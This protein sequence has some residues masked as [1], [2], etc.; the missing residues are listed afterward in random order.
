MQ[1]LLSP[2][3]RRSV[4][5][6]DSA[7]TARQNIST[8]A[9][10]ADENSLLDAQWY[11]ITKTLNRLL[12]ESELYEQLVKELARALNQD[13]LQAAGHE[14]TSE[15]EFPLPGLV[16]RSAAMREGSFSALHFHST[17]R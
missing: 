12:G 17:R 14:E 10:E 8:L 1:N 6:T 16:Y 4:L 7:E 3:F 2:N 13:P 15:E 9:G 11:I 5:G